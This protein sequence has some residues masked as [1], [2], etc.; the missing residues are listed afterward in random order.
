MGFE[1]VGLD[2][3]EETHDGRR[4][5][6]G[7][8][9]AGEEPVLAADGD[10]PDGIFDRIVVDRPSPLVEHA[11]EGAPA[12]KGVVD[13]TAQAAVAQNLGLELIQPAFE[14]VQSRREMFS[15]LTQAS[16]IVEIAQLGFDDVELADAVDR[17]LRQRTA[18][19]LVSV[20]KA[21]PRMRPTGQLG[22]AG[23]K[24]G[25]VAAVIIDHQR[26]APGVEERGGVPARATGA[27]VEQDDGLRPGAAGR[28]CASCA[29]GTRPSMASVGEQV[30][31][32]GLAGAG[33]ELGD[34][35]FVGMQYGRLQ[36]AR[37][38]HIHQRLQ[39]HADGA[40]P[41]GQSGA[42]QRDAGA[43][44]D[45]FLP[46][47]RKMIGVLL[48][49]DLG[50]QARRDDAPVENGGCH[51][52]GDDRLAAAAGVLGVDITAHEEGHRLDVQLLAD[53]LA[54]LH[55]R[56][57]AGGAI[58]RGRLG[59]RLDAR[60][61][62]RQ[63]AAGG[64]GRATGC[65]LGRFTQG[66]Q[67]A[68]QRRDIRRH[69]LVEQFTLGR[70]HALGLGRKLHA[71]QSR[72]LVRELADLRV[73]VRNG[74]VTLGDGAFVDGNQRLLLKHHRLQRLDVRNGVERCAIHDRAA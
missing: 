66:F 57:A 43:G 15:S 2:G 61:L 62:G 6:A 33:V 38:Q 48:D 71:A 72:D 40:D 10:G 60:Q 24:Q 51:R 73:L 68:L 3:G 50:Q 54:D 37:A 21:A 41:F 58:A 46:M 1:A 70:I 63:G 56:R 9:G 59:D 29:C 65:R 26:P 69:R 74:V 44:K 47:E 36:Q 5:S 4:T 42:R 28:S 25:L 64:S 16:G 23:G 13:G 49:R 22:D 27:V 18:A 67:L 20:D 11:H 19:G 30:S 52:L 17:F 32:P 34:R 31:S 14:G 39:G 12:S 45:R 8:F 35:G 55:Q 7:A 53:V